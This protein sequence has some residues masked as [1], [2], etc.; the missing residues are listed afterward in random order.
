MK[1]QEKYKAIIPG[2]AFENPNGSP[3]RIETDYFGRKRNIVNPSPGPFEITK[4]SK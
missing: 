3:I 1:E 4:S 2:L